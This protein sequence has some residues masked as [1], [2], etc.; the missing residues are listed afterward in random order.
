MDPSTSHAW[1]DHPGLRSSWDLPGAWQRKE[2]TRCAP[3]GCFKPAVS[4]G[5][6]SAPSGSLQ[7]RFLGDPKG[8]GS[9]WDPPGA[10]QSGE[11][12]GSAPRDR[13]PLAVRQRRADPSPGRSQADPAGVGLGFHRDPPE[14]CRSRPGCSGTAVPPAHAPA[15]GRS[16]SRQIPSRSSGSEP[17]SNRNSPSPPQLCCAGTKAGLSSHS[18]THGWAEWIPLRLSPEWIP[19][20]WNPT[21][22]TLQ[23]AK[24]AAPREEYPPAPRRSKPLAT[25]RPP[26]PLMEL[27]PRIP[28]Q[29]PA[30]FP[31]PPLSQKNPPS[32]ACSW[33][34][35]NP[36]RSRSRRGGE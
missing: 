28:P 21:G 16:L 9:S 15:Q 29:D 35:G 2:P 31:P 20:G 23:G 7:G 4:I 22:I 6:L 24:R 13:C 17:G 27:G 12:T 25:D 18:S 30:G 11:R 34:G 14:L 19:Q 8:W 3:Q 5:R 33:G 26:P 10:P 36:A 32:Q 1:A